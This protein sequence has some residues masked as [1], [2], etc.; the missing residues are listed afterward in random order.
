L[1]LLGALVLGGCGGARTPSKPVAERICDGARR[2]ATG[3]LGYAAGARLASRVTDN[4]DCVVSGHGRLR[5]RAVTQV[6]GAAY[7]EFDTTTS[8]QEQVYGS[9]IHEPGQI[10]QMITVP[11]AVAAVW[12]P[13]QRQLVAT[14]ANPGHGG[15]YLTVTVSGPAGASPRSLAQ[16]AAAATFAARPGRP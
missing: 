5:V 1:A 12:I 14:N 10:P 9:G 6:G 13:A 4:V 11:G 16:A 15:T 8:H 3:Q 2:A 7:T